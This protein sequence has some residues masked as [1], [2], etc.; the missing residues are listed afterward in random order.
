VSG[1]IDNLIWPNG[2]DVLATALSALENSVSS[3]TGDLVLGSAIKPAF[4]LLKRDISKEKRITTLVTDA[5][6][7]RQ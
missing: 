1:A 6:E 7:K 2:I 3:E 4:Q 5:L